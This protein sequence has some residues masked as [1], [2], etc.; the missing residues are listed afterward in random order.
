[1]TSTNQTLTNSE[2]NQNSHVVALSEPSTLKELTR[3]KES[4]TSLCISFRELRV[5]A[6]VYDSL[7]QTYAVY[8]V[9]QDK[10]IKFVGFETQ[11][12]QL[13]SLVSTKLTSGATNLIKRTTIFR[14]WLQTSYV[15]ELVEN[16]CLLVNLTVDQSIYLGN[17]TNNY[18]LAPSRNFATRVNTKAVEFYVLTRDFAFEGVN[19]LST[20]LA[21]RL[22]SLI[23]RLGL[24]KEEGLIKITTNDQQYIEIS[25]KK[26]LFVINSNTFEAIRKV[27]DEVVEE[28]KKRA[29][30]TLEA[31]V[32]RL[33]WIRT[34][35]TGLQK[36][37]LKVEE[38]KQALTVEVLN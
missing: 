2:A 36:Q 32:K 19:S 35:V 5:V 12:S 1:M 6:V 26:S 29:S 18:I 22:N 11:F 20:S 14:E 28:T 30:A 37:F 10:L 8:L 34:F 23:E 7:L 24:D 21:E 25:I 17:L 16:A 13:T 31:S 27:I 33:E 4:V 3:L 38:E 9:Y 15:K